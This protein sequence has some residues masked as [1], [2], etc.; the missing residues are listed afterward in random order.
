MFRVLGFKLP[1]MIDPF[2]D[3]ENVNDNDPLDYQLDL[4]RRWAEHLGYK[5]IAAI[6]RR[7]LD[8]LA[9]CQK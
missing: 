6:A 8:K 5:V 4:V 1:G 7:V 3:L 9:E 2:R